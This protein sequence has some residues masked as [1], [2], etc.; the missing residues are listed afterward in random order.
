MKWRILAAVAASLCALAL[1]ALWPRP[2]SVDVAVL[3]YTRTEG[4]YHATLRITNT[5][6]RVVEL[7]TANIAF[8]D[9]AGQG[10]IGDN[11]HPLS[12]A[13]QSSE[14]ARLSGALPAGVEI[15]AARIH[16]APAPPVIVEVMP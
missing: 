13:P 5:G 12:I 16:A 4:G 6:A 2:A 3:D 7:S 15:V 11:P 8:Y 10:Y 1:V 9:S 14:P